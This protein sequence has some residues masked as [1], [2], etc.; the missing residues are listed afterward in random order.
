[1]NDFIIENLKKEIEGFKREIKAERVGRVLE[2]GD[3]I[4]KIYGLAEVASQE[5]LEF[6]TSEGIVSGIAFNLEEDSVGAIIL[7][8]YLKIKEGDVVKHTGRVLSVQ[9]GKE[10]LGRVINPLGEPI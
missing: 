4:A 1:M 2:V 6:E 7:G 5:M 10:L 3:G 8:D 9:V